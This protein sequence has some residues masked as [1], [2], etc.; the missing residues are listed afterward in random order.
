MGRLESVSSQVRH[1]IPRVVGANTCLM[2][3]PAATGPGQARDLKDQSR[4]GP[5]QAKDQSRTGPGEAKDQSRT[6]PGRPR[7]SSGQVLGRPRI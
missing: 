1:S 4:T 5:G 3:T 2:M 7:I 6:G